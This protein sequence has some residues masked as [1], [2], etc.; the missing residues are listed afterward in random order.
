MAEDVIPVNAQDGPYRIPKSLIDAISDIQQYSVME[1][2]GAS[3][4]PSDYFTLRR[5]LAYMNIGFIYGLGDNVLLWLVSPFLYA[6]LYN[7]LPLFGRT[8]PTFF[9]K[10]FTFVLSKYI[11]V[12]LLSLMIYLL[13]RVKGTLTKGCIT[14]LVGGYSFALFIRAFVFL[15]FY[16]WLY[17]IWPSMCNGIANFAVKIAGLADGAQRF[18]RNHPPTWMYSLA[19]KLE[20]VADK[21]LELRPVVL[22]TSNYETLFSLLTIVVL[23][24]TW[25]WFMVLKTRKVK[26]PYY[27]RF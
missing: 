3:D 22:A 11:T 4:I 18:F 12:S 2:K 8:H 27:G 23:L 7:Y 21:L 24:I 15:F 6:V 14:S 13:S 20:L 25:Y 17:A 26:N 5:K 10:L 9:D 1:S 19:E 16:R